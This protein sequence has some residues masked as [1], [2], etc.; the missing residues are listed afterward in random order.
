MSRNEAPEEYPDDTRPAIGASELNGV[1]SPL[2]CPFCGGL[3][4]AVNEGS[5][6]RWRYAACLDCGAQA[7]EI[8]RQ[9]LGEGTTEQW[10]RKAEID[11]IAEWNKRAND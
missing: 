1:V 2:P 5:T 9:T 3:R 6:F 10:E 11:A 4:I 7:G 8:R